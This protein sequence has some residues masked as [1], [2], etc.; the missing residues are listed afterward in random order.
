MHEICGGIGAAHGADVRM[1]YT[2]GYPPTVNSDHRSVDILHAA[3]AKVVKDFGVPYITCGAEDFSFFL[4]Q[5]PGCFFFVGAA[6]PG[7]PLR[8]HHKSVFDFSED[9]MLVGASVFVQLVN[10]LLVAQLPEGFKLSDA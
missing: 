3:A 10:D 9:A 7:E 2:H 5:R 1:V 6:L 8:P 4:Q